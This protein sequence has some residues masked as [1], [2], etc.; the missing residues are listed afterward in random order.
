MKIRKEMKIMMRAR[1]VLAAAFLFAGLST[2]TGQITGSGIPPAFGNTPPPETVPFGTLSFD[3]FSGSGVVDKLVPGVIQL[4]VINAVDRGLKHNLGL[5]LSQEEKSFERAQHLR[6]L[7]ILLPQ[8]GFTSSESVQQINLAAFGIPFNGLTVVGPFGLFDA[9]PHLS[10]RLLDLSAVNRLRSAIQNEKAASLTVQDARELVVLVVGN[11]YL[12]TLS[13]DARL[14]TAR[15]QLTTAQAIYRQAADMKKAGVV[16]G[17]DVL[18]A[19]VQMQERQQAVLSAENQLAKQRMNLA[20]TI[21]LPL[22][23]SFELT[24]K[25]PY[26]P[27]A[28]LNLEEE[29]ARTYSRRPEYLAAEARLHAAERQVVAARQERLPTLDV[30]G[31]FGVFGPAPGSAQQ[32]FSVAAGLRVPVFDGGRI[33]SDVIQAQANVRQLKSQ[34][35]DLRGRIELEVRSAILDVTTSNDQVAVA[36]QSIVLAADQLKQSQDRFRSGVS[37]SLEV[38]QAQEAVATANET[39]IQATYL[40]NVAKLSLA[41]ALGVA[42]QRTRAFFGGK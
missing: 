13:A 10:D 42:E 15:A 4:S 28:E 2:A 16:P 29:L 34:L 37:T 6:E 9:R 40:N 39:L 21:G 31:D 22:T 23:Q 5:I 25:V 38:V 33:K 12:L 20:R 8:V 35:E 32:T 17:I 41:R 30:F 24:D 7:S 36:Q 1:A 3:R 11:E 18:R 26:S 27:L 19:Q 14:E